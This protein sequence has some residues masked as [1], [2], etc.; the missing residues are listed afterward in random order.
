M[1]SQFITVLLLTLLYG[2]S[3]EVSH[4]A[5]IPEGTSDRN[6]ESTKNFRI[7]I[8][9]ESITI[10]DRPVKIGQ[11][12]D[13]WKSVISGTARC[14]TQQ[15]R[16]MCVWDQVGIEVL[17]EDSAVIFLHVYFN[18]ISWGT[19]PTKTPDGRP[20][21]V[22]VDTRPTNSFRGIF[23]LDGF[24]ISSKTKFWQIRKNVSA[25]RNV[26]CDQFTGN[27]A[28]TTAHF[29][30]RSSIYLELNETTSP[31][32]NL[33]VFALGGLPDEDNQAVKNGTRD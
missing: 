16:E 24:E 30:D 32:G 20:F 8:Q 19:F 27:C 28:N 25:K 11:S 31:N 17:A 21:P 10:N 5:D 13:F 4:I 15:R 2:C 26:R 12:L 33:A 29:D 3:K 23:K 9:G 22:P 14:E 6:S 7:S 1:M 18:K